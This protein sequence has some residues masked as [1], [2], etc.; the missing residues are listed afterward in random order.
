M[1]ISALNSLIIGVDA[2]E[3]ILVW[4]EYSEEFQ[5]AL[6]HFSPHLA[7]AYIEW[8]RTYGG[9]DHENAYAIQ[10]TNDCGYIVA[11]ST[12]PFGAEEDFWVVKFFPKHDVAVTY[13]APCKTVIG[14]G[15]SL[16]V[17]VTVKNPGYFNESFNVTAYANTTAIGTQEVLY[18]SPETS[19]TLT[20][21]WNTTGF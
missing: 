2:A 16:S 10:Q 5:S 19:T 1:F 17:N 18:L 3:E 4:P 8:N 15:Y 13:V 20:F 6:G 7:N 14:Q 21:K 9:D 11:G 12:K